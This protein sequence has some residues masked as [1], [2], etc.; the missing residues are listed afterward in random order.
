MKFTKKFIYIPEL[1]DVFLLKKK[2]QK[3]II[4]ENSEVEIKLTYRNNI[5]ELIK[6]EY[7]LFLV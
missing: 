6:S 3:S 4:V 1:N 7:F 2:N 5:N